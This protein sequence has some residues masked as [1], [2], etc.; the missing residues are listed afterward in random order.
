MSPNIELSSK[1][2]RPSSVCLL[3][4]VALVAS[5]CITSP[6]W[7]NGATPVAKKTEMNSCPNGML[8]DLEDGDTQSLKIENRGGYWYNYVD[9][10]GTTIEPK[11]FVPEPGGPP[12]S[13]LAAHIKG[14]VAAAG[15][16]P[17]AGVGFS[18]T[19]PKSGFDISQA[20]GIRFWAKGPGRI[21]VELPDANTDPSGDR[22][23]D[24]Y[25]HFGV[26]LALE[27]EW[28]RYTIPFER[29]AQDP[30][31]GD[32]APAVSEK[33]LIAIQ[34]KFGSFGQPYDLWFDNIELVGC[35][36]PQESP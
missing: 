23:K 24:C 2:L 21:H 25:N 1:A 32:R 35:D 6:A 33:E 19:N 36:L 9:K 31:W 11:K 18:I 10:F 28:N 12:G 14:Q 30:G 15:D 13:K 27:P 22:C 7:E 5:G 4:V 8:D 34:W 26:Y 29:F 17:Y 20:A 16:Y 3:G